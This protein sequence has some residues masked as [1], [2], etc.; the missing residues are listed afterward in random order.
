MSSIRNILAQ[1]TYPTNLTEISDIVLS[2]KSSK[3]AGYDEISPKISPKVIKSVIPYISK[4][5][6]EIFNIS[7][8]TG[9]FLNKLKIVKVS[10][11]I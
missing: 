2:L 5:L 6:C 9:E 7:I 11:I 1:C 8:Y 4:P 3:S 10:H